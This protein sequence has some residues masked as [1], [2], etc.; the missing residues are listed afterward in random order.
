MARRAGTRRRATTARGDR[1]RARKKVRSRRS[2][3]ARARTSRRVASRRGVADGRDARWMSCHKKMSARTALTSSERRA[4]GA[5]DVSGDAREIFRANARRGWRTRAQRSSAEVL[6]R[7]SQ[8][9]TPRNERGRLR[10]A[11]DV[12]ICFARQSSNR[13]LKWKRER[14]GIYARGRR[15]GGVRR[16][17]ARSCAR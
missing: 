3:I 14:H 4:S 6:G 11:T 8:T 15:S 2:R 16:P 10:Q 7:E 12:N 1:L 5:L 9:Q 13:V 17:H